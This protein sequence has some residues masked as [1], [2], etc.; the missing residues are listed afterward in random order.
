[1][2]VATPEEVRAIERGLGR[3]GLVAL[4]YG[5]WLLHAALAAVAVVA[6]RQLLLLTLII[7]MNVY[8]RRLPDETALVIMA[9]LWLGWVVLSEGVYRHAAGR[10]VTVLLRLALRVTIVLVTLLAL[11]AVG[12]LL[13]RPH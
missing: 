8:A 2:P 3:A 6:A 12:I 4:A 5:L 1:M 9:V 10:G 11:L 7:R 13:A